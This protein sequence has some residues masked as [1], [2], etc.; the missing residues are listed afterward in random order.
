MTSPSHVA[1][2]YVL[3]DNPLVPDRMSDIEVLE[4]A[5]FSLFFLNHP[6]FNN[7]STSQRNDFIQRSINMI[8]KAESQVV[9]PLIP[10]IKRDA[11]FQYDGMENFVHQWGTHP[12]ING[13]LLYDDFFTEPW[14][15]GNP[16]SDADALWVMRW[17]YRMIRNIADDQENSYNADLAPGKHIYVTMHLPPSWNGSEWQA[18]FA[19]R[20][21]YEDSLPP[22]IFS[23]GGAWDICCPYWYPHRSSIPGLNDQMTA[24]DEMLRTAHAKIKGPIMPIVQACAED[25]TKS[26]PSDYLLEQYDLMPQYNHLRSSGI[27]KRNRSVLLYAAHAHWQSNVDLLTHSGMSGH[28]DS[29]SSNRMLSGAKMLIAEHRRNYP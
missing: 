23:K 3:G 5:G 22:D 6:H 25:P 14:P 13:F 15:L 20:Q 7:W 19:I 1:A 2:W 12:R 4:Q 24:F 8:S 29:T 10:F 18:D 11:W 21:E 28:I 9:L 26:T 27:L 16:Q 17:H